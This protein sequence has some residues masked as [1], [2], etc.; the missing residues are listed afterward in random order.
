MTQSRQLQG[1]GHLERVGTEE[2]QAVGVLRLAFIM[3]IIVRTE[4]F[5]HASLH[6][7]GVDSDHSIADPSP[8][9]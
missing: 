7:Y 1:N 9:R 4:E 2:A 8:T 5:S 3:G 6:S